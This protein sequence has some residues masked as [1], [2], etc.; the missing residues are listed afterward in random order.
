MATAQV[1]RYLEDQVFS[2][3]PERVRLL[4]IQRAIRAI[5]AVKSLWQVQD[6]DSAAA[7]LE[8]AKSIVMEL[9]RGLK[10]LGAEISG[11]TAS[12]YLYVRNALGNAQRKQDEALL[13]DALRVL[14][15]ERDTWT[16]VCG[17]RA[18]M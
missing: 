3:S 6:W 5:A 16:Q 18:S 17:R 14:E 13:D 1:S 7:E 8:R 12:V 11:K 10:P 2:A 15:V 4:L 9:T